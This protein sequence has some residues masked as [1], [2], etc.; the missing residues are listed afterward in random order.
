MKLSP[1][2][3]VA[4]FFATLAF[5]ALPSSAMAAGTTVTK[6]IGQTAVT[7]WTA[8]TTYT[9]G[10]AIPSGT[11]ISYTLYEGAGSSGSCA[12][13]Q[14]STV[15]ASGITT[16]SYTLPAATAAGTYCYDVTATVNGVASKASNVVAEVVS[17]PVP[18]APT[19]TIQ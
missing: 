3:L 15:V 1:F 16:L 11:K 14:I 5:L 18:N 9:D 13:A 10:A 17:A 19:A 12:S 7:S 8:P 2:S 6:V 4:A